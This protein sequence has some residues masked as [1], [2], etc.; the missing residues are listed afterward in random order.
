MRREILNSA[1]IESL[2]YSELQAVDLKVALYY[3]E[4]AIY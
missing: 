1:L 2:M 4:S 3:T